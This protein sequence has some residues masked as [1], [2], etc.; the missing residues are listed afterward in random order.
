MKRL[1]TILWSRLSFCFWS[2]F[3]LTNPLWA[4]TGEP[5]ASSLNWVRLEGAEPCITS[6]KLARK[7][8]ELLGRPVFVSAV[9]SELSIEGFVKGLP[10]SS[11]WKARVMVSDA[12]GT[13][14]GTR[15][16]STQ[17]PDC[18]ALDDLLV[19]V[20]ALSIDPEAAFVQLP[21]QLTPGDS[22][23][24][25]PAA[26]LLLDLESETEKARAEK[27]M[28]IRDPLSSKNQGKN[29]ASNRDKRKGEIPKP[30]NWRFWFDMGVAW[31][32]GF[33][34]G[35]G[36]GLLLQSYLDLPWIWPL[37]LKLLYWMKSETESRLGGRGH[38]QVTQGSIS[39]CPLSV[40]FSLGKWVVY[41]GGQVSVED[42]SSTGLMNSHDQTF[43]Q[44]SAEVGCRLY[45]PI[46]AL[47]GVSLG[48][49]LFFPIPRHSY[50]IDL[51]DDP[52][53]NS[54]TLYEAS[55]IAARLEIA[56]GVHF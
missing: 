45:L 50:Q 52:E 2:I 40:D 41:G 15:E 44:F 21:E 19:L 53:D 31:G 56:A 20:I 14:L 28:A 33:L 24:T 42:A 49:E 4:Q 13:V 25:D 7:V 55:P 16:V 47:F 26:D 46:T 10:N 38:L 6:R 18:S 9:E 5:Q 37:Q 11:G 51:P 1:W 30:F 29:T 39:I 8:E 34:P 12:R 36:T 43:W 32:V 23:S 17:E 54:L 27:A 35:L 22:D 3:A 48:A